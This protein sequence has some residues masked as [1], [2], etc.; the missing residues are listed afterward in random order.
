MVLLLRLR[1]SFDQNSYV[2]LLATDRRLNGG[3]SGSVVGVDAL[4]RFLGYYQLE[5]QVLTSHTAE[6]LDRTMT[7]SL[8]GSAA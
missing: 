8:E 7:E 6:P 1:Q 4:I 3:G 2:G 5:A